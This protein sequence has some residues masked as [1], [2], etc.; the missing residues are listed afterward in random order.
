MIFE[1]CSHLLVHVSL[2][3]APFLGDD[4]LPSSSIVLNDGL[5]PR[6]QSVEKSVSLAI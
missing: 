2:A 3:A 4:R 1:E 5:P 6:F